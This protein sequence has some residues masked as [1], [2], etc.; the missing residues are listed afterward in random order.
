MKRVRTATTATITENNEVTAIVP[1]TVTEYNPTDTIMEENTKRHHNNSFKQKLAKRNAKRHGVDNSRYNEPI[2]NGLVSRVASVAAPEDLVVYKEYTTELFRGSFRCNTYF[3]KKDGL[4]Y[5][6]A[7][8]FFNG[9]VG[10]SEYECVIIDIT[11]FTNITRRS[12]LGKPMRGE[13]INAKFICDSYYSTKKVKG[14]DAFKFAAWIVVHAY[15]TGLFLDRK[16]IYDMIPKNDPTITSM[17]NLWINLQDDVPNEVKRLFLFGDDG[18]CQYAE[19]NKDLFGFKK[20]DK[21]AD[22]NDDEVEAFDVNE[23]NDEELVKECEEL[24]ERYR[25]AVAN[26]K[27]EAIVDHPVSVDTEAK[28][29]TTTSDFESK[30]V[31]VKETVSDVDK[32]VSVSKHE[33]DEYKPEAATKAHEFTFGELMKPAVTYDVGATVDGIIDELRSIPS[34]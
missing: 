15:C 13:R 29:E 30:A 4:M 24:D 32:S 31:E 2:P 28:E 3:N 7:S 16:G 8:A 27:D 6:L 23:D 22:V 17:W 9:N 12:I 20:K 19:T 14:V 26:D 1:V 34:A 25:T 10:T 21:D 18:Y 5:K 33:A 11:R